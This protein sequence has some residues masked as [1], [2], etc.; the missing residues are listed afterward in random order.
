MKNS[1]AW[2]PVRRRRKFVARGRRRGADVAR[3]PLQESVRG[4]QLAETLARAMV[5]FLRNC[6]APLRVAKRGNSEPD[7]LVCHKGTRGIL[8][9][10]GEPFHPPTRTVHDHERDRPLPGSDRA[11][12]FS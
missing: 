10:V 9:V 4:A 1:S 3:A 6:R 2:G 7:F 5:M 12:P 8:E 11:F